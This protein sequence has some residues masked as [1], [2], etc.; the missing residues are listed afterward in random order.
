MK[1]IGARFGS[2]AIVALFLALWNVL[3][4]VILGD[5]IKEAKSVFWFAY[6]FITLAFVATGIATVFMKL[7]KEKIFSINHT[8]KIKKD[9]SN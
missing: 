8:L 4:F 6:A 1:K 3:V 7:T 2:L 9:M 5:N